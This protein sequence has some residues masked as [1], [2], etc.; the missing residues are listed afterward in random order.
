[1]VLVAIL[2]L[3]FGL[4]NPSVETGIFVEEPGAMAEEAMPG[5]LPEELAGGV[6][7]ALAPLTLLRGVRLDLD[8]L[9]SEE[10]ISLKIFGSIPP[11]VTQK[12]RANPFLPY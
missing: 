12:G 6:P 4:R 3:Y 9:K 10:F 1:M 7:Q 5:M 8:F 2:V 11:E